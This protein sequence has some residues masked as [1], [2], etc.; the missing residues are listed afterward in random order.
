MTST[1]LGARMARR[2]AERLAGEL[3]HVRGVGR[4][5]SGSSPDLCTSMVMV[6]PR[7]SSA[8]SRSQAGPERRRSSTLVRAQPEDEAPDVPDRRVDGVDGPVDARLGLGRS[9]GHQLGHV[10]E[11]QAHAR[12]A[13]G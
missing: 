12:T 4:V 8:A 6:V 2:V 5:Q 9:R 11:G 13:P 10:L 7:A 1:A 3:Q